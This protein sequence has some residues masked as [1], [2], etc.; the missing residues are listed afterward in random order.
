M[1]DP[2]DRRHLKA[3]ENLIEAIYTTSIPKEIALRM[4]GDMVVS[5]E[6][7]DRSIRKMNEDYDLQEMRR[8]DDLEMDLL[9]EASY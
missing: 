2:I 5:K 6:G 9:D 8:K 3:L 1:K 7:H 4:V